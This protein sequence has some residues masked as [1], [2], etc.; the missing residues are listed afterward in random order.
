M[1]LMVIKLKVMHG[2]GQ[3][4][5]FPT[6]DCLSCRVNFHLILLLALTS[7]LSNSTRKKM[8][9]LNHS[10]QYFGQPL[11]WK[12]KKLRHFGVNPQHNIRAPL[13]TLPVLLLHYIICIFQHSLLFLNYLE[14]GSNKLLLNAH[15]LYKSTQCHIQ[16][17]QKLQDKLDSFNLQ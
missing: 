2:Q 17:E 11:H 5:S 12:L 10:I 6:T 14:D 13:L 8:A 16:A 9:T 7:P 3:I 15:P 4:H 1:W